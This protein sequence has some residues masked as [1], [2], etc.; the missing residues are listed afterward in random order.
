MGAHGNL[1]LLG[2][3]G[4]RRWLARGIGAGALAFISAVLVGMLFITAFIGDAGQGWAERGTLTAVLFTALWSVNA[5]A[6]SAVGAWQA[7]ESGAPHT[8]AVRFAGAFGPVALIVLV[9]VLALGGDGAS[10]VTVVVEAI[11]EVA[12]A[13][14]GADALARRLESAW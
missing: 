8:G 2:E 12:A 14:A 11:V 6:A 7:A 4:E 3:A 1:P 5:A 13:V 10:T 9:S